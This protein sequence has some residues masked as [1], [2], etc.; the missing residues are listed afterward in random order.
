VSSTDRQSRRLADPTGAVVNT[1]QYLDGK[2]DGVSQVIIRGVL[3]EEANYIAGQLHGPYRSWWENGTAK[4]EGTFNRGHRVGVYRW[5]NVDG[6]LW[7]EHDYGSA[8]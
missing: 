1:A 6:S 3:T 8:L 5:Y 2:L 7:Q 4:E